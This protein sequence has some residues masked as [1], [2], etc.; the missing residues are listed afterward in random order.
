MRRAPRRRRGRAFAVAALLLASAAP[1]HAQLGASVAIDSDYR[2]RGVTLSGSGPTARASFNYDAANGCYGGAS[3]TS[4]E[5]ARGDRYVQTLGYAGCAVPAGVG[6]H[7]E[8]GLAFLHF[9]DGAGYDFVEGYVGVLAERWSARV[10]LAPDYFGRNVSTVY[11]EL[12]GHAVLDEHFR[13]FGHAGAIVRIAGD[14]RGAGRSRADV[15]LGVGWAMRGFDLQLAW[16]AA[17]RGGPYPAVYDR[18]PTA[19]VASASYSF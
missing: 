5:L 13:V 10:H 9:S 18:R 4:V 1:A 7:V 6:R 11:A 17:T 2:F 16:L 14:G 12:D 15:R 3:A 19:W 8:S